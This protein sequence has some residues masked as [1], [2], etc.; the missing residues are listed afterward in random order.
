MSVDGLN[1]RSRRRVDIVHLEV[2]DH[3]AQSSKTMKQCLLIGHIILVGE[4][5]K[6]RCAQSNVSANGL[7]SLDMEETVL[8]GSVI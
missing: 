6:E 4:R 2:P 7:I 3:Y 5:E 8:L 1:G